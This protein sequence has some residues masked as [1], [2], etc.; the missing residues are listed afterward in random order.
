MSNKLDDLLY[1]A[2]KEQDT[3]SQ[4]LNRQILEK[5]YD[6]E[7]KGMNKNTDKRQYKSVIA[8]AIVIAIL[9]VGGGSAYA[10]YRYLSAEQVIDLVSN[11]RR[12]IAKAFENGDAIKM[13]E[14]QESGEY[15][16]RMLGL[17][18]GK[19]IVSY[20]QDEEMRDIAEKSMY[21]VVEI[22][23]TDG[24]AM[25]YDYFCIS[26]LI[27]GVPFQ[28]AN[29]ATMQNGT[30]WF[31]QD[32]VLYELMECENLEKFADR[33]VWV[34]V[35][36]S[37]GAEARAFALDETTG[38]YSKKPGYDGVSALF[39]LP[40]DEALADKEAAD[41]YIDE[42]YKESGWDIQEDKETDSTENIEDTEADTKTGTA[43]KVE[44][45][46]NTEAQGNTGADQ[47]EEADSDTQ[48]TDEFSSA[49][50]LMLEVEKL[51]RE[52]LEATYEAVEGHIATAWPDENNYVTLRYETEDG[53]TEGCYT[54]LDYLM[55]E[56]EA[57]CVK[58][59][60]IEDGK[61]AEFRVVFRNDDGS[62][63]LQEFIYK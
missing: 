46:E 48:V 34:S 3:P 42:L 6:Q 14:A 19:D 35:A 32:D 39:K 36:E 10:S 23:K 49:A 8:A 29:N 40:L 9:L 12:P 27:G 47:A 30:T 37:F 63:T 22:Y 31:I 15:T 56:D 53:G 7:E 21:A 60:S 61:P 25:P 43:E 13:D 24:S 28:V 45:E 41:A 54:R 18:S 17:A 50:A 55:R 51:T 52:E 20:I 11:D 62:Y 26:P 57:W 59:F 38:E 16:I 33:G 5:L 2:L 44:E 4:S 58:G 1:E